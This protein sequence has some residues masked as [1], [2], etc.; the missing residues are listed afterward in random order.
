MRQLVLITLSALL[1]GGCGLFG[2][3]D[4]RTQLD[5][6][7]GKPETA[8]IEALGVPNKTVEASD[9]EFLTYSDRR[10][11]TAD[12]FPGYDF[13]GGFDGYGSLGYRK[14]GFEANPAL[15]ERL[16]ETAIEIIK[17]KVSSYTLRGNSC[18]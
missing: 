14:Q 8:V 2:Q 13:Y 7:I 5:Q 10:A 9:R 3:P 6:L 15:Y 12:S 17:N 1:L 16:C 4:R 11:D 18:S